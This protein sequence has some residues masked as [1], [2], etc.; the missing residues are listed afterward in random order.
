MPNGCCVEFFEK[1]KRTCMYGGDL[2]TKESVWIAHLQARLK[3]EFSIASQLASSIY[4]SCSLCI[5]LCR[6]QHLFSLYGA[7]GSATMVPSK[8]P[9][10]FAHLEQAALHIIRLIRDTPG[11]ENTRTAVVGDLALRHHLPECDRTAVCAHST[12]FGMSMG[13]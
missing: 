4:R 8:Q 5:E 12:R 10:S 6:I 9:P 2:V 13:N 7:Q 11:L 3:P 1:V